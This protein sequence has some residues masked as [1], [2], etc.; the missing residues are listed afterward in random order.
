M[1]GSHE[2]PHKGKKSQSL[3]THEDSDQLAVCLTEVYLRLLYFAPFNFHK[4]I[5]A[6]YWSL[7]FLLYYLLCTFFFLFFLFVL[8]SFL[9]D[10]R[11]ERTFESQEP[12][13]VSCDAIAQNGNNAGVTTCHT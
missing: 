11:R 2:R 3:A 8:F 1:S 4:S 10:L 6:L 9:F 13:G 7:Y 12:H 5:H